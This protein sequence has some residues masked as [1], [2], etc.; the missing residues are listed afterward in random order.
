MCIEFQH[1]SCQVVVIV[2]LTYLLTYFIAVVIAAVAWNQLSWTELYFRI[3]DLDLGSVT[4]TA[5]TLLTSL[6]IHLVSPEYM[7][8]QRRSV[9]KSVGCFQRR[10]FCLL[11]TSDAADE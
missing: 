1:L 6:L 8:T 10:L 5:L 7:F 11:Y 9:A 2:S 4:L 3:V